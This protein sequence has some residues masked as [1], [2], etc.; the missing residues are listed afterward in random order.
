MAQEPAQTQADSGSL[1][2]GGV[3][4]LLQVERAAREA[5]DRA[6]LRFLMVN[7]TREVVAYTHGAFL[8]EGPGGR[9]RV[10]ALSNLPTV[11]RSAPFVQWLERAAREVAASGTAGPP[12]AVDPQALSE[13]V[14][15]QWPEMSPAHVLWVP[16]VDPV[17]GRQGVLWLAREE[18][19][20]ATDELLLDHLG[21]T[22]GHSL[23]AL[24]RQGGWRVHL[25]RLARKRVLLG[26]LVLL[27]GIL[28]I[29][30]RMTALAPAEVVPRDPDVVAAPIDGT[31]AEV[32]V[33]T[34]EAV[35]EGDP[36]VR[37]EDTVLRNEYRVAQRKLRVA[38][39]ELHEAE[40]G[41]FVDERKKGRIAQL[42]ARAELRE[43][44]LAFARQKLEKTTV[45]ADAAGVAVVRDPEEMAGQPVKV[46]Q[47]LLRIAD[48]SQIELRIMLPV[49]DAIVL[50]EDAPVELFLDV[51]PLQPV[52]AEVVRANY[53]PQKSDQGTLAYRV[54]ARFRDLDEPLRIGLRGTAQIHGQPV[55][56][57]YYLF[58]RPI[59]AARQYLGW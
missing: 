47:R 31:V 56:L 10:E 45:R 8:T 23:A 24:A 21:S 54:I 36:V 29:P 5:R 27:L 33:R 3:S 43:A 51:R 1:P 2:G 20:G 16:L 52:R 4:T 39:A 6:T 44:E 13:A 55:T 58:R 37:F 12:Q 38:K 17:L 40:Q 26:V 28:L 59:T 35:A 57:F 53:R 11:D 41:A 18:A 15:A 46:G 14:R 25:R 48:P 30:V 32:L 22:Y 49:T 50:H 34:N 42:E 9:L 7:R 19:F